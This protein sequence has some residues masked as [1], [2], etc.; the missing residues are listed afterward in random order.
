MLFTF[1][2]SQSITYLMINKCYKISILFDHVY[3]CLSFESLTNRKL[4]SLS[5]DENHRKLNF[6]FIESTTLMICLNC[7]RD[8]QNSIQLLRHRKECLKER[9]FVCSMC[10]KAFKRK[11]HLHRHMKGKSHERDKSRF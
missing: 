3:R 7:G 5:G 10:N 11:Y 1:T 8:C 2:N 9:N 4:L 6:E